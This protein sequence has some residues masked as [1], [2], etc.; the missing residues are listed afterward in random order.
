M[1]CIL[2]G[3]SVPVV[4]RRF[5]EA[6][7]FYHKFIGECYA[8]GMMDGEA[9]VGRPPTYPYGGKKISTFKLM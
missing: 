4:L 3:C 5:N 2:F 8:H 6:G 1:I 9:I 7:K